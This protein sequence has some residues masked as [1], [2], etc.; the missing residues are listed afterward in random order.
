MLRVI[1]RVP[2]I[3][4][5]KHQ[6]SKRGNPEPTQWFANHLTSSWTQLQQV[7]W[8]TQEQ[9]DKQFVDKPTPFKKP[10]RLCILCQHNIKLDYKNPRLLSQFVSPINGDIYDKHITG[11]CEMQ[12]R[13]L[14]NEIKRSRLSMLMPIYYKDPKYNR[15]P[16]L[17]N[18]EKPQRPNP[19]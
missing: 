1:L 9:I 19:Y 13:I 6:V 17:F 10:K 8:L 15:D 18:P 16:P 12:Q 2:P 14:Q 3:K 4:K 7:K 11:L 5:F